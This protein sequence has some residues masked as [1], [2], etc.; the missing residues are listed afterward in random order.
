MPW[1]DEDSPCHVLNERQVQFQGPSVQMEDDGVS[2]DKATLISIN[3][4]H[5]ENGCLLHPLNI[6]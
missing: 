4:M 3:K 6:W 5:G 1:Q 2:I